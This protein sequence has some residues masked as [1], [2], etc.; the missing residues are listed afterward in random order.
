MSK[1]KREAKTHTSALLR[2][3]LVDLEGCDGV[4]MRAKLTYDTFIGVPC[5]KKTSLLHQINTFKE[6]DPDALVLV[7]VGEMYEA[8]GVDATL[9]NEHAHLDPCK[10]DVPKVVVHASKLPAVIRAVVRVPDLRCAI[11]E[12]SPVICTPRHRYLAQV[13]DAAVPSYVM[14]APLISAHGRAKWKGATPACRTSAAN[15][16][17][18]ERLR[19]L[20]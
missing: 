13:V 6:R 7:R 10:T 2:R 1:R 3:L 8:Y 15:C 17:T 9:L 11:Y 18:I 20:V 19:A 16:A 14:F 5:D 4:Q 12:E